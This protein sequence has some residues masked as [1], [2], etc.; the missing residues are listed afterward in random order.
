[1]SFIALISSCYIKSYDNYSMIQ[2]FSSFLLYQIVFEAIFK[3]ILAFLKNP[4]I[5]M[6]S[7]KQFISNNIQYVMSSLTT[8]YPFKNLKPQTI[9][10]L[11]LKK[12][13][14]DSKNWRIFLI[15]D[16]TFIPFLQDITF[17]R[18]LQQ[19]E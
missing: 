3:L 13:C 17:I 1:M 12:L 19:V 9:G 14:S 4:Q 16:S 11:L 18:L 15:K 10:L 5:T 7:K 6:K 2:Y 8:I